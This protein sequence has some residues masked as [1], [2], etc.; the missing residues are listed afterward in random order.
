MKLNLK[1]LLLKTSLY[2]GAALIAV[3]AIYLVIAGDQYFK[4]KALE[5][6]ADS[7]RNAETTILDA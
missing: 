7:I 2:G 5:A 1:S 6:Q 4:R 3:V